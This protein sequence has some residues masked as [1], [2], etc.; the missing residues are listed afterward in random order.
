MARIMAFDYGEKRIGIAVTDPLKIIATP[1]QTVDSKDI[2]P[3]LQQYLSTETVEL[4]VVGLPMHLNNTPAH[5]THLVHTFMRSLQEHFP[6][7]ALKT[8]DE[9]FTSKMAQRIV[10]QSGLKKKE[11]QQKERLDQIS[12]AIILQDYLNLLSN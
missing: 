12:A 10:I 4:F 1:L 9:R 8:F 7:I 2:I 6:T 11:R 3:F 5:I